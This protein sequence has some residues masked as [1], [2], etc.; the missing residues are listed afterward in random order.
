MTFEVQCQVQST[1]SRSR[2]NCRVGG[3]VGAVVTCPLEVVK[4]R[5]QSSV[6]N[7]HTPGREGAVQNCQYQP[8]ARYST[9]P[10]AQV[11]TVPQDVMA[12][13]KPTTNLYYCIRYQASYRCYDYNDKLVSGHVLADEEPKSMLIILSSNC[14]PHYHI[15]TLYFR[16]IIEHEGVRGLFKGLGPNLIGVAPSR[17]VELCILSLIRLTR[18]CIKVIG[19]KVTK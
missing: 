11:Y 9:C 4:T 2:S 19:F 16:H 15:V 12:K 7:F 18:Y 8:K 5:L 3:T 17:Y 10:S 6:A 1:I 13:P 14:C